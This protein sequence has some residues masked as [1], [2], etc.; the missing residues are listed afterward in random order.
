MSAVTPL[1]H[2]ADASPAVVFRIESYPLAAAPSPGFLSLETT[3]NSAA[4]NSFDTIT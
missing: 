4:L 2:L 3:S 1:S